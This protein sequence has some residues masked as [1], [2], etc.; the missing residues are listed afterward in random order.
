L[1]IWAAETWQRYVAD[2]QAHFDEIAESALG[3]AT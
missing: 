3:D 1:E 2:K